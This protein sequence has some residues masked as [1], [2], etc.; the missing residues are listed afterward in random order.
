MKEVLKKGFNNLLYLVIFIESCLRGLS[1][2]CVN[3]F[4][5]LFIVIKF[6]Y[7]NEFKMILLWKV[8]KIVYILFNVI[9]KIM[10]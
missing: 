2:D 4:K 7:Y 5:M 10:G 3:K 1:G 6:F 8:D 9:G